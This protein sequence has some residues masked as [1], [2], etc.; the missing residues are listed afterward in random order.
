VMIIVKTQNLTTATPARLLRNVDEKQIKAG[1]MLT[2]IMA[3]KAMLIEA[4]S[5]M[6]GF[7]QCVVNIIK[8]W[9]VVVVVKVI[10]EAR[11]PMASHAKCCPQT[12]KMRD[13]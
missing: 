4:R 5:R 13:T 9:I 6:G 10:A 12:A 8:M 3:I 7:R 2:L 1:N 11:A